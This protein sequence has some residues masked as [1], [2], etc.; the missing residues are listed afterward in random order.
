MLPKGFKVIIDWFQEAAEDPDYAN[1]EMHNETR[2]MDGNIVDSDDEEEERPG[3]QG[4]EFEEWV[5]L[6]KKLSGVVLEEIKD[7]VEEIKN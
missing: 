6:E 3:W 5:P 2:D 1:P 4:E 7:D